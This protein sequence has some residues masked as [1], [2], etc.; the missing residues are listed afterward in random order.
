MAQYYDP[1]FDPETKALVREEFV[2]CML[3]YPGWAVHKGF[4]EW[5]RTMQRRPSPAEIVILIGRAMKPLTDEIKRRE[6]DAAEMASSQSE[7]TPEEI[8]R[9]RAFAQGVMAKAGY[10]T[11]RANPGPRR[12][13]VTDED[14][15]EMA[16]MLETHNAK[17]TP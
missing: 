9:R 14:R 1:D 11:Q 2:R 4:D 5:T 12:E 17:A 13:T 3:P 6:K 10:A 7:L 16:V 8:E 15:A